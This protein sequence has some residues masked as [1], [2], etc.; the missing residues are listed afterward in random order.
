MDDKLQASHMRN[1]LWGLN[2]RAGRLCK[3]AS[4]STTAYDHLME[5]ELGLRTSNIGL[6]RGRALR[7]IRIV[8]K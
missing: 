8:K 4:R 7:S 3:N 6:I 2:I 5:I 1:W